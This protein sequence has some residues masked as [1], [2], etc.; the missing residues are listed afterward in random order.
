MK[1]RSKSEVKL[2][3]TMLR[4]L[5]KSLLSAAGENYG[6]ITLDAAELEYISSAGLRVLLNLKKGTKCKVSVINVSHEIYDI[7]NVTGFD[8]IL[9]V[10]KAL[11]ELAWTKWKLSAAV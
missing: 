9:D 7:F 8:N 6:D 4:N 11:R 10:K 2:T 3:P 1:T 5:K